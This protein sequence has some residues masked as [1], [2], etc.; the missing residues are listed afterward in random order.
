MQAVQEVRRG[1]ETEAVPKE[2]VGGGGGR[3]GVLTPPG[4]AAGV[5]RGVAVVSLCKMGG[6]AGPVWG[7]EGLLPG[8][9]SASLWVYERTLRFGSCAFPPRLLLVPVLLPARFGARS[10]GEGRVP[11]ASV[12]VCW[13]QCP[14]S[15]GTDTGTG[16]ALSAVLNRRREAG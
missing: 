11:P 2:V 10:T 5:L 16:E 13:A 7:S 12:G 15:T 8:E 3:R 6:W 9:R 4:V 14:Q 1:G